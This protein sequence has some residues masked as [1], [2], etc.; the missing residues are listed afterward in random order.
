LFFFF[1][2]ARLEIFTWL[3]LFSA[4][5]YNSFPSEHISNATK[6]LLFF[7]VIHS[8]IQTYLFHVAV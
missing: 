7:T 1:A 5:I 8:P 6:N 4:N 2:G 3:F